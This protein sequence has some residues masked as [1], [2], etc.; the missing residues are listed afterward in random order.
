MKY[1]GGF[2]GDL[3]EQLKAEG[4]EVYSVAGGPVSSSWDRV[5]EIYHQLKGGRVDYGATHSAKYGHLRYGES[6][7]TALYPEWG[8]VDPATG[9]IRKVRKTLPRHQ[10]FIF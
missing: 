7:D 4:Y 8:T 5:T 3:Q 10:S 9:K 1:W 2:Q 6:Y